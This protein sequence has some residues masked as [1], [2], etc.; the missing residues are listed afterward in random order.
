MKYRVLREFQAGKRGDVVDMEPSRGEL[1]VRRGILEVASVTPP[2]KA[3]NP[4]QIKR[5]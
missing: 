5:K 2:N 4:N 1:Y 3:M